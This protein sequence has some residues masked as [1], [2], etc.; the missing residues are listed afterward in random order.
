MAAWYPENLAGCH[1]NQGFVAVGVAEQL[2]VL[3]SLLGK[4]EEAATPDAHKDTREG[5]V[6]LACMHTFAHSLH[7]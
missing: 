5:S 7:I 6:S 2:V 3:L 4:F 1:G